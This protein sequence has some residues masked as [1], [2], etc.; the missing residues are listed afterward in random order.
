MASYNEIWDN[1]LNK[2]LTFFKNNKRKPARNSKNLLEKQLSAWLNSQ[3]VNYMKN[4]H[5]MKDEANRTKWENTMKEFEEYMRSNDDIWNNKLNDL[6]NFIEQHKRRPKDDAENFSERRLGHWIC[7]QNSYY[8]N[9]S[10]V[11]KDKTKKDKF[12]NFIDKYEQYFFHN[13][14]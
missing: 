8:K 4:I 14:K 6:E 2:L 7:C 13:K 9:N 5:S 11:M 3:K 1:T 10:G 12:K